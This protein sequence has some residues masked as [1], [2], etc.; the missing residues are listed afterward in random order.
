[1]QY[2]SFFE[3]LIAFIVDVV[4]FIPLGWIVKNDIASFLIGTAYI[5]WMNG[6]Y[7]ATVGKMVMGIR[8]VKENKAKINY[9]DAMLREIASYLSF[10][11]F[12]IGYLVVIWDPKKQAWHDKIAKTIVIH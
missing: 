7:G 5:V 8:I 2:A 10:V 1:M 3:R 9:S 4:L 6:A 11:V 12:M